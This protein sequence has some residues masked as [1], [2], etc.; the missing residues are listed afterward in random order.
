[1]PSVEQLNIEAANTGGRQYENARHVPERTVP[2]AAPKAKV[3]QGGSGQSSNRG[4]M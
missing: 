4:T 1:M 3:E 2:A